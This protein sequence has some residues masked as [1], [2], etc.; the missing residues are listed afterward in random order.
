MSKRRPHIMT[1]ITVTFNLSSPL[2][3]SLKYSDKNSELINVIQ[4]DF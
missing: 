3:Q 1:E 2:N 4:S